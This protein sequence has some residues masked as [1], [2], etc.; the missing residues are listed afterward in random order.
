MDKQSAHTA[1]PSSLVSFSFKKDKTMSRK[2]L[3]EQQCAERELRL[4]KLQQEIQFNRLEAAV[5]PA[6][7][8]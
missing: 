1:S 8:N 4:L 6:F 5:K 7:Y 2:R 3:T